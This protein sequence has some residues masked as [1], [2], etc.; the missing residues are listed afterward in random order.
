[1]VST[2]NPSPQTQ[3]VPKPS[4][5]FWQLLA[6]YCFFVIARFAISLAVSNP[7]VPT[8][9][10]RYKNLAYSFFCTGDFYGA[11]NLG[12]SVYMPNIFYPFLISPSFAFK[13]QF[14]IA[15]KLI[16]SL[17]INTSLFPAYLLARA[18]IE[19]KK[20]LLT[21]ITILLLPSFHFVSFVAVDGL[22]IPL[23]LFCFLYCYSSLTKGGFNGLWAGLFMTLLLLTKPAACAYVAGFFFAS[24]IVLFWLLAAKD[25]A[26][27]RVVLRSILLAAVSFAVSFVALTLLLKHELSYKLG[28]YTAVVAAQSPQVSWKTICDMA[29]AY[30]FALSSL[31]YVFLFVSVLGCFFLWR[32]KDERR[33]DY[34]VLLALTYAITLAYWIL[35]AR[36]TLDVSN[37]ENFERL[38]TRY[39]FMICPLFVI[40]FGVFIEKVTWTRINLGVLFGS[41]LF[42]VWANLSHFFPRHV[43]HGLAVF[44]SPETAWA[45]PPSACLPV[46]SSLSIAGVFVLYLF[47]A[48]RS[49]VPYLAFFIPFSLV[50]N[51]GEIRNHLWYDAANSQNA[52]YRYF[53]QANITDL[54]SSV[55]VVDEWLGHRLWLAFW[56]PYDYTATYDLPKGSVIDRRLVP[57]RTHYLVVFDDY[58]V[59]LP[60]RLIGKSGKCSLFELQSVEQ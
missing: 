39:L 22:N 60:S 26:R 50:S 3:L 21:A 17:L 1:M 40:C 12:Y 56:L 2:N 44:D 53:V 51:Y 4:V 10:I 7:L 16:N 25:T 34:A 48:H 57:I 46:V 27:F 11:E 41:V 31:G 18:F 32:R 29:I 45:V 35:V 6:I 47:R 19:P 43:I 14:Y 38:H 30:I 33:Y 36:F 9:E 52:N 5:H 23:F 42:V 37:W 13:E 20:A 58:K 59:D 49:S 28:G 55:A 24:T 15:I 54:N 8:D